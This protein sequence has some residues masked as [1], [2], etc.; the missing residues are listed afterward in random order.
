MEEATYVQGF[1]IDEKVKQMK[2]AELGKTG[3]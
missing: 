2:Y 3:E 1:H